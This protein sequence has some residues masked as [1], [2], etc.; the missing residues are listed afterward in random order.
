MAFDEKFIDELKQKNNIVDVVGKYC[1]LKRRGSVN[2]W[3]CCPLPG[4]SE[5]TP[6]FTVNEPGQF[7]KCFGCGKGGDVITFVMIM[8]NLDYLGAVRLL[9]EWAGLALPDDDRDYKEIAKERTDRDRLLSLL[10]ET[11][12]Y[13]VRNLTKPQAKPFVEYLERRGFDRKTATAFGIGASLDR[14]ELVDHLKAK[15]YTYEEMLK[16]G[17]CKKKERKDENGKDTSY[18]Y[19]DQWGRLIVPIINNLGNVIAFGGRVLEAKPN[20][21]KYKNTQETQLFVKNRTLYNINNLK[22]FKQIQG[23]LSEV[24]MVEGYMDTISLYQAGFKNVVASMGTSLTVEQARMVKRY[25]DT[26]IVSYDGDGAGQ[27][28]TIR[29]LEIFQKEGL[30]VK[31][32]TLPSG[33]DPDDVIKKYGA[34]SYQ[35]LLDDAMPL[36]DFKIFNLKAK[37]NLKDTQSKRKYIA[38]AI[39][40]IAD[41]NLESEREDLL[42][43]LGK[44]TD[45]TFESLQRDLN[46][47]Q[48]KEEAKPQVLEQTQATDGLKNAERFVLCAMLFNKAYSKTFNPYTVNFTDPVH[49]RI[50]DVVE[51][52]RESGK[53]I[54]PSTIAKLFS[55]EE[56][57]EYNA[58][59]ASGDNVFGLKSEER[60]FKDCLT[61]IKRESLASDLKELK[62][63][64]AQETDTEKRKEIVKMIADLTAKLS[65]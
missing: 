8:E 43:K 11:A 4:H 61:K 10:K 17:V 20:F 41:V 5:K 21:A 46:K 58:V 62:I 42:R 1:V 14:F 44:D 13:Y 22:K 26:V 9:A 40:V 33:L 48:G 2:H 12:L 29:G 16:C 54:F 18:I 53:E 28:A 3:A 45:T 25:A 34:E 47:L 27:S 59:L 38:E 52:Y 23:N 39:K 57:V 51:E 32:V 50:C 60:F 24:I 36:V 15:G 35:K 65:K 56:L 37:Y 6:S 49:I 31:V 19:D 63:I 30:N 64:F 55:Q 7:F